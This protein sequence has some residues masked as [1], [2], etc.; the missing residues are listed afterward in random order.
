MLNA[1]RCGK[2]HALKT[3][4]VC[5]HAQD[6][7]Y[8]KQ[9]EQWAADGAITLIT[10]FSRAQ[11]QKVYVQHRIKETGELIWDLLQKVLHES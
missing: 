1:V 11:S 8:G 10:A 2:L 5:P 3:A 9:L 7:L 4:C 6:Y